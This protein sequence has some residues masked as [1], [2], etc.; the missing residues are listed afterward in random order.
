[1]SEREKEIDRIY[2]MFQEGHLPRPVKIL[3]IL[4]SLFYGPI[5]EA[6]DKIAEKSSENER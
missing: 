6:I 3:L 2:D 5:L 1:M 4:V